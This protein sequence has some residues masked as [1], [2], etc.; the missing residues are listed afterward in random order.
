MKQ[1]IKAIVL[2]ML[3]LIISI[4]SMLPLF[5]PELFHNGDT[6]ISNEIVI[7]SLIV[8]AIIGYMLLSVSY[9]ICAKVEENKMCEFVGFRMP[10]KYEVTYCVIA[11]SYDCNSYNKTYRSCR[12]ITDTEK[13]IFDMFCKE[14]EP[15]LGRVLSVGCGAANLFEPYIHNAGCTNI[16]GID[17]SR[18]QVK[19]AKQ[20]LP[21]CEFICKN[22]LHI[23]NDSIGKFNGIICMYSLF[24]FMNEDQKAALHKMYDLLYEGGLCVLNVRTEVENAIRYTADWCGDQMYWYLP[25]VIKVLEWCT[26]IGF[27][28]RLYDNPEN[29]DYKFIVLN[30]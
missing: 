26:E 7:T 20:N 22:F 5:K 13:M 29:R 16:T 6:R 12:V 10:G 30:K 1:Y 23:N 8:G 2:N 3:A 19:R 14:L 15:T 25:G 24:N 4:A 28:C 17:I 21:T 18:E 9:K 27:R 11:N